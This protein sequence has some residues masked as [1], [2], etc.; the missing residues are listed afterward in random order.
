MLSKPE[1]SLQALFP[2]TIESGKSGTI[3]SVGSTVNRAKPCQ[4]MSYT[5]K[6]VGYVLL[7]I[8]VFSTPSHV[9][10]LQ[11][12]SV[13]SRLLACSLPLCCGLMQK[14]EVATVPFALSL[15]YLKMCNLF[16]IAINDLGHSYSKTTLV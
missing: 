10:Y 7:W 1:L 16:N 4:A 11:S 14:L 13:V 2:H 8:F 5:N 15:S 6:S 12:V 3:G 9:D